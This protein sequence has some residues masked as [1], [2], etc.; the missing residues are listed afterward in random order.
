MPY[1]ANTKK[2]KGHRTTKGTT[3]NPLLQRLGRDHA[4]LTQLLDLLSAMLDRFHDGDEPDYDVIAESL[5][6]MESYADE[7]HHPS[8]ELIF[9]RLIEIGEGGNEVLSVLSKQ[10]DVL[11]QV[12]RDFRTA[13]EGILN[14]EV[15]RRD[16]VEVQGRDLVATLRQHMVLEDTV[17][18]PLA[19]EKLSEDDWRV[20][21]ETAP[22][23]NDPI[24]GKPDPARF[25]SLFQLLVEQAKP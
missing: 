25:N 9:K 10:H 4:G 12:T 5:E 24:F 6:Y 22:E 18:F 23:D 2:P 14:E 16:E 17:A 1:Y 20:L 11:H 15:I 3:M 19:L 7:I 8:E 21:I 13:I